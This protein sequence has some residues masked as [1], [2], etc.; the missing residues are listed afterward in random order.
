MSETAQ[1]NS[2]PEAPQSFQQKRG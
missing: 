2:D 1:D